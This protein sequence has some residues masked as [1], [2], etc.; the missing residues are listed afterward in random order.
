MRVGDHRAVAG[1]VLGNRR[2]PRL[3]HARHGGY[4][5]RRDGVRIAVKSPIAD[6]LAH[7]VVQVDTGGKA[8]V[9]PHGAQF[10][11][12]QPTHRLGESES[13]SL[14]LVKAPAEKPHRRQARKALAKALHPTPFMVHRNQ[15]MRTAH[16]PDTRRQRR[17]LR[18]VA[19]I[20]RE[21]QNAADQR[22]LEHANV[23]GAQFRA[24][25]VD[26]EGS[27]T[28][29]GLSNTAIDSTCVVCGNISITPAQ[30]SSNPKSCTRRPASRAKLPGWQEIYT[31]RRGRQCAIRGSSSAAPARGGSSSTRSKRSFDQGPNFCRFE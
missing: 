16:R 31:T 13:V 29:A 27:Q 24:G 4:A 23:V 11:G 21:Q 30:V 25:D 26:H 14:V 5:K 9:H 18:R 2:H 17:D 12:H 22:M 7:A 3:A 19:V 6:D 10:R 28:H 20:P 8:E 1:K 15:Q